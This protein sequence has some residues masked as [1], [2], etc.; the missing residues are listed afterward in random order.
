MDEVWLEAERRVARVVQSWAKRLETEPSCGPD[1]LAQ[2]LRLRVWQHWQE[3]GE[4][5]SEPALRDWAWDVLR[6]FGFV[7]RQGEALRSPDENCLLQEVEELEADRNGEDRGCPGHPGLAPS[8][9]HEAL[10]HEFWQRL[11]PA[12]RAQCEEL[13]EARTWAE[14]AA[15]WGFPN[16]K[17]V[18]R[19]VRGPLRR[20]MERE[21]ALHILE[22]LIGTR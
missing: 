19:Y 12:L 9:E 15:L 13:A 11:S 16:E 14:L 3:H 20:R 10:R 22:R 2:E 7:G 5:P 6:G 17:A 18:L 21:G 1:D 8:A 4:L